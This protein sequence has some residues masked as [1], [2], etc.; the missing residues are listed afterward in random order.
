MFTYVALV[1]C[2]NILNEVYVLKLGN[3]RKKLGKRIYEHFQSTVLTN[4][5]KKKKNYLKAVSSFESEK[6][7]LITSQIYNL[8]F[9]KE[10][11]ESVHCLVICSNRTESDS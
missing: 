9:Q 8:K 3:E 4:T 6:K 2:E 7:F 10:I 11:Y 1:R 5:V